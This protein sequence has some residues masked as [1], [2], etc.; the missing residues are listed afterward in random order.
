[1]YASTGTLSIIK[2]CLPGGMGKSG[3]MYGRVPKERCLVFLSK[4]KICTTLGNI[5]IKKVTNLS[6]SSWRRKA[7]STMP[8]RI[9]TR[10][11]FLNEPR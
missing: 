8:R 5:R 1:M 10:N 7:E 3:A 9:A 2:K 6:L 4:T 11:L